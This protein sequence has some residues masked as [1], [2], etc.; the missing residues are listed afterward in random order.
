MRVGQLGQCKRK[1]VHTARYKNS[2]QDVPMDV[3]RTAT[4]PPGLPHSPQC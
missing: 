3:S 1:N 4:F 2:I